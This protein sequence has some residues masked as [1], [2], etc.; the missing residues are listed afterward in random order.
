MSDL[1]LLLDEYLATRRALGARLELPGR[2]LKRFA[3]FVV[4]QEAGFI[5]TEL[6]LRWATEPNNAQ[7]AQWANRLGMVRRF[8][9]Y[10]NAVDPRHEVPP[11]GLLPCQYRRRQPYIYTDREIADLIAAAQVLSGV[12]GLRPLTYAT[13]LGLLTVTGLRTS[14]V[15]SLDR[16]DVDLAQGIVTVRN[17]KFGKSRQIHLHPSTRQALRR[18]TDQR[19]R[20]CPNPRGPG[21]FL[22]EC[23]TRITQWALRWTFAKLSRQTGLRG[24]SKSHGNGPRLHDMRHRF[25]VNMLLRWYRGGVDV[26][27]HLPHLATWLGHVHVSDTYWYLTAT[28]ELM[29]LAARRLDR[30]AR[31]A[32]P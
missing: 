25:A 30:I 20:L 7:P 31:R 15:L 2:L 4:Q 21:F 27:R 32:L 14:E 23:G 26:E 10:A 28:P 18:Y 16:D 6:A 3:A 24:P 1:Q 19:D 29:Q 13:L 22:A 17:S 12:T 9:C 5:T 11:Q 8:A